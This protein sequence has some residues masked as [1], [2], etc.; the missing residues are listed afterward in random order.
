MRALCCA[1]NAAASMRSAQDQFKRPSH[2]SLMRAFGLGAASSAAISPIACVA[3]VPNPSA[4]SIT[5]CARLT[6][7]C[8]LLRSPTS[9][10]CA[11]ARTHTPAHQREFLIGPTVTV[12]PLVGSVTSRATGAALSTGSAFLG[13]PGTGTDCY[14][15][16][17]V[18]WLCG[19][20]RA[21]SPAC[22][23]RRDRTDDGPWRLIVQCTVNI[24]AGRCKA[25]IISA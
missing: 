11:Y 10:P 12:C 21:A 1:D 23:A 7:F 9:P 20:D 18:E 25:R 4:V 19:A 6:C 17:R 15:L 13:C 3:V 22:G 5:I 14:G 24:C 2:R 8:G 16:H